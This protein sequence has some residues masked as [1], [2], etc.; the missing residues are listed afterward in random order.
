MA[1]TAA[2]MGMSAEASKKAELDAVVTGAH[3]KDVDYA[4]ASQLE[5]NTEANLRTE[6]QDADIYIS[7][8]QAAYAASGVLSS[9]SALD[10]EAQTAGKLEQGIQQKWIDSQVQANA[11]RTQGNYGQM[12]MQNQ[13]DSIAIQNNINQ[14]KGMSQIASQASSA[15]QSGTF[16]H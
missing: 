7:K 16:S 12:Y 1:G 6:R 10:V 9:G 8:Q 14:M 11:M 3:N 4:A 5:T 13:A 2:G 15:Y